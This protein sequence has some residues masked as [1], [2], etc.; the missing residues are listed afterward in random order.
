[1][2]LYTF[3]TP[4]E[5]SHLGPFAIPLEPDPNNDMMGRAGF[6]MHGDVA[7][8][9][10]AASEGC[11]IMGPMVRHSCYASEDQQL[12]VVAALDE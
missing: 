6:F 8:Q 9:F 3:G 1:V 10:R 5:H 7:G 2:G 12:R 11:I 4:V